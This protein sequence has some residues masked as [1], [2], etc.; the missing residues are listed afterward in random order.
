MYHSKP[1]TCS[2]TPRE[3]H[4]ARRNPTQVD[5]RNNEER[6]FTTRTDTIPQILSSFDNREQV[7]EAPAM[8]LVQE[9]NRVWVSRFMELLVRRFSS[10]ST[11]DR[12]S[13]GSP[14]SCPAWLPVS[15]QTR[16]QKSGMWDTEK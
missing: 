16:P 9:N 10:V 12:G 7:V 11:S 3:N 15:G 8:M 4:R 6:G 13:C 5:P 14:P 2:R 1:C